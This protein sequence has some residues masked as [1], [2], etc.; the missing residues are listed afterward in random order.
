MKT[1]HLDRLSWLLVALLS[2]AAST[3]KVPTPEEV[4]GF[5]IGEDRKL[6]D[7]YQML[8]YLRGL[9]AASDRLR[10]EE[11]GRTTEGH[12]FAMAIITSAENHAR[13]PKIL[14]VQ[15]KLADPRGRDQKEL[16][17]LAAQA[18]AV[19]LV[20]CSIHADEVG[21]AQMSLLLAHTLCSRST[22][23]VMSILN[24]VVCLLVPSHNPDGQL[25]IVDWYRRNAA[26]RFE[27]APMP[28]LYQKYCGHDLNRDWF[29]FT[30]Q[31]TR[32]T[33]EKIH[34]VYHPHIT[35]DMHEMGKTGARLFVPPYLDP[36]EPH[37]DPI[38]VGLLG[39]LGNHVMTQLTAE[40][41]AGIANSAIFD[42]WTPA[43]AYPH[44]HG[45]IRFLTEVASVDIATPVTIPS[46]KLT[47]GLNYSA[48]RASVNFPMPWNGGTWRLRDIVDYDLSAAI[49]VLRHA[50]DN[51]GFWVRSCATVQQRAIQNEASPFAFLIPA[52]QPDPDALYDLLETLSYAGVDVDVAEAN[53]AIDSTAI[54]KDDFVVR[55]AQPY[56][57]FARAML[58]NVP[59][60][61]IRM[62]DG[63]LRRP[64]DVTAH[65]LPSFLGVRV[66]PLQAKT[67]LSLR[68]L[69]K[70]ARPH[71]TVANSASGW[72]ILP[73]ASA[74][75]YRALNH[76]LQS[77][78]PCWW[79][80]TA[81]TPDSLPGFVV[82]ASGAS[83]L[84]QET[85]SLTGARF[86]AFR[87]TDRSAGKDG[88]VVA[89][90]RGY[91][92][93]M[94]RLG[95]YQSWIP[96][97]DEGWT[98]WVLE[99]HGFEYV[100]LHNA[101][102]HAGRL[103]GRFDAILLPD[104]EAAEI[105]DGYA[106]GS[107]PEPYAGG[108]GEAGVR[109]LEQFVHAGG[110]LLALNR[111]CALPIREFALPV[112]NILGDVSPDKFAAPGTVLRVV[113]DS[114]QVS[115]PL[116]YGA[117]REEAVFFMDSPA[118]QIDN[119]NAILRYPQGGIVQAGW[120]AVQAPFTLAGS[121][122]LADVP[123]GAGHVVLFGFRPQF[124]GQ[125]RASYK[126]LFNAILYA[127]AQAPV[128]SPAAGRQ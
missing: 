52:R 65:H 60:P 24:E 94:P 93:R 81:D 106:S 121:S 77:G 95:V 72:Y 74:S 67:N 58:N 3:P 68:P 34:Q 85:A 97:I 73:T 101:D 22:P 91:Q 32:L 127:A 16:D 109:M 114:G 1:R 107:T 116:A 86:E 78:L 31:E 7:Y 88:A 80:T 62:A 59:Y 25:K 108:L 8:G 120:F 69:E 63:S 37:V 112:R 75:T 5:A 50:A 105:K 87:P 115:Q 128:F 14:D 113:V 111:A 123:F 53:S 48:T 40:G 92:L 119:G 96:A 42:G 122:A 57:A 6:A 126:F 19:V 89:P 2:G 18:K 35:L 29:M 10:L 118:F 55:T 44:Y 84:I 79:K 61:G 15:A 17:E 117:R 26:T 27:T 102:V 46:E 83:N 99:R 110:T 47:G 11:I 125:F 41:K 56:G 82:N 28:W 51:R 33:V 103:R 90:Q 39:T 43:R 71:G 12:P 38:L 98:R 124:R 54:A 20:N 70:I 76:L 13:L 100:T 30:Q 9:D 4:L 23:E 66:L 45:G 64:Y 104:Q 49:A 21:A 36:I